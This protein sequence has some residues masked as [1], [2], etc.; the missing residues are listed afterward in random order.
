MSL[1][2]GFLSG[3]FSLFPADDP[4]LKKGV[5]YQAYIGLIYIKFNKLYEFD[6]S[7]NIV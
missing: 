7:L 2:A 3:L 1:F 4:S 6:L 5:I